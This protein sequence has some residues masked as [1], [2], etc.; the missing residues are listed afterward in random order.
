MDWMICPNHHQRLRN[1][2]RS[3]SNSQD[4]VKIHR[5]NSD[6]EGLTNLCSE[7]EWNSS[8]LFDRLLLQAMLPFIVGLLVALSH[9][10]WSYVA[11]TYVKRSSFPGWQGWPQC[12]ASWSYVLP[13]SVCDDA[14][15]PRTITL[16]MSMTALSSKLRPLIQRA[17]KSQGP[18]S[19]TILSKESGEEYK[20]LVRKIVFSNDLFDT[21]VLHWQLFLSLTCILDQYLELY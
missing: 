9:T 1:Y 5:N 6:S 7:C 10:L 3:L 20:K 12:E 21:R 18:R 15:P 2:I 16:T 8:M 14:K 4:V 17:V 11:L 13:P 19:M